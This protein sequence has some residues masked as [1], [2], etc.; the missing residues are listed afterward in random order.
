L[1]VATKEEFAMEEATLNLLTDSAPWSK[2]ME[3]SWMWGLERSRKIIP[4]WELE[5]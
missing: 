2:E 3:L 4:H 5:T 1:P